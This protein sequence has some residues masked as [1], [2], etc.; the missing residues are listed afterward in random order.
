M[1]TE[2]FEEFLIL[3]STLLI[4]QILQL[5]QSTFSSFERLLKKAVKYIFAPENPLALKTLQNLN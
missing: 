4:E 5:I 3:F 1:Y 2:K